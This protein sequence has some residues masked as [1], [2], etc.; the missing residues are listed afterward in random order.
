LT[1]NVK[2][3]DIVIQLQKLEIRHH[4]LGKKINEGT[5]VT[6]KISSGEI[7][8]GDTIKITINGKEFKTTCMRIE[9]SKR[10]SNTAKKGDSVG[11]LLR[12]VSK[13][14]L[15]KGMVIRK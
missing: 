6:G 9:I 2:N 5:I 15:K 14:D 1:E 12:G 3:N 4:N 7:K 11:L 8:K 13:A 10:E